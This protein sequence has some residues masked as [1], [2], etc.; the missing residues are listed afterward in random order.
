MNDD[1]TYLYCREQND[2]VLFA[3]YWNSNQNK[4]ISMTY[5]VTRNTTSL[6]VYDIGVQ[7]LAF[8]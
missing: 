5:F 7:V 1:V 3:M 2:N 6:A 8:H 4:R